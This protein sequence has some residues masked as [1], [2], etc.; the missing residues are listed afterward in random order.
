M[1]REENRENWKEGLKRGRRKKTQ[2][3]REISAAAANAEKERM[4]FSTRPRCLWLAKNRKREPPGTCRRSVC[5]RFIP[6]PFFPVSRNSSLFLRSRHLSECRAHVGKR[7]RRDSGSSS[8]LFPFFFF[9]FIFDRSLS[10]L[11]RA[12]ALLSSAPRTNKHK[13][14]LRGGQAHQG[15]PRQALQEGRR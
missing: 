9:F 14:S 1:K 7:E 12:R 3:Q 11:A 4:R 15:P 8:P 2:I 10:S 6:P 5:W 13:N